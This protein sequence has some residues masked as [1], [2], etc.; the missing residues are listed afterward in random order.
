MP[1]LRPLI[2]DVLTN[3]LSQIAQCIAIRCEL[4]NLLFLNMSENV[5]DW[6]TSAANLQIL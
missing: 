4:V 3:I 1:D 2:T 6:D 5:H